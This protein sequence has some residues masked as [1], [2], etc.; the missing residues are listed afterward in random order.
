MSF[1]VFC[2]VSSSICRNSRFGMYKG[3]CFALFS[4]H[5]CSDFFCSISCF[6]LCILELREYKNVIL[7]FQKI[8]LKLMYRNAV[9]INLILCLLTWAG[10]DFATTILHLSFR[11]PPYSSC[12]GAFLDLW[13]NTVFSSNCPITTSATTKSPLES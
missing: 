6:C 2:I 8:L 13:I 3:T 5:I 1:S 7:S 9:T 4:D 11:L 12:R 10:L